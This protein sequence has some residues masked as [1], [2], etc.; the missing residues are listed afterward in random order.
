M[1]YV[2][3]LGGCLVSKE[4][5]L[6]INPLPNLAVSLSPSGVKGVYCE[7]D[8]NVKLKALPAGRIWTANVTGILSYDVFKPILVGASDRDKWII[9]TYSYVNP[10]T[11]CGT[12]KSLTVYVQSTSRIRILT[13][14]FDT[15]RKNT[16]LIT[17]NANYSFSSKINWYHTFD[18]SKASF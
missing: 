14:D 18:P 13:L 3:T 4:M 10:T 8:S 1:N 11:K 7:I 5:L 16:M 12:A 9:L 15:C 6:P 17:L 2:Y